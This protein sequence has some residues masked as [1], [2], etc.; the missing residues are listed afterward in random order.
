MTKSAASLLSIIGIVGNSITLYVLTRP[1]FIKE[2]MFRYLII[3]TLIGSIGIFFIWVQSLPVIFNWSVND[4]YCKIYI[5][6]CTIG[7]DSFP[8][9]NAINSIDRLLSLKYPHK[10]IFRKKFR[11]QALVLSSIF[12]IAIVTDVTQLVFEGICFYFILFYFN[13]CL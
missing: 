9:V 13:K 6:L 10:F 2:P 12:L 8:W 5:Y 4:T 11:N 3:N 7:Y 1:N